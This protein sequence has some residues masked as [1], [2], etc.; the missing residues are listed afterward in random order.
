MAVSGSKA[1]SIERHSRKIGD[2]FKRLAACWGLLVRPARIEQSVVSTDPFLSSSVELPYWRAGTPRHTD[3]DGVGISRVQ[4]ATNGLW[5]GLRSFELGI[6]KATV[7]VGTVVVL[8]EQIRPAQP[9]PCRIRDPEFL[10]ELLA[11]NHSVC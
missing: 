8:A 4:P 7:I 2:F 1:A 3:D 9:G 11:V 10:R 5:G 6:G